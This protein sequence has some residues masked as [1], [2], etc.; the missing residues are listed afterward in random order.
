[1]QP[2]GR[3]RTGRVAVRFFFCWHF[4]HLLP[5]VSPGRR[6]GCWVLYQ[7]AP[8]RMINRQSL[9]PSPLE[10]QAGSSA[11]NKAK[12]SSPKHSWGYNEAC[13]KQTGERLPDKQFH[14]QS[15]TERRD[16]ESQCS[17][18]V[19]LLDSTVQRLA[20]APEWGMKGRV[21]GGWLEVISHLAMSSTE[22]THRALKVY[23]T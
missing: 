14:T 19:S 9:G 3:D 16:S 17:R 4:P 20:L 11:G 12:I 13:T 8:E 15:T 21:E 7:G 22:S 23:S 1:M 2:R 18:C 10:Q 5:P 6:G